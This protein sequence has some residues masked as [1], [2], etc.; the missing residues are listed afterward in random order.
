MTYK[1][2]EKSLHVGD[3]VYLKGA[4]CNTETYAI[5]RIDNEC[6]GK[7]P[8][9]KLTLRNMYGDVGVW[10]HTDVYRKAT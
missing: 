10:L 5:L 8:V 2:A 1:E 4:Y 9:L 3:Y 6:K 7:K